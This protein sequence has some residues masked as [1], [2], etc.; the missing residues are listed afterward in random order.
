MKYRS[1]IIISK[2]LTLPY[3][4][5]SSSPIIITL[6]SSLILI[7]SPVLSF[8]FSPTKLFAI[9]SPYSKEIDKQQ[10]PSSVLA[11]SSK[12]DASESIHP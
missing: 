3:E 5:K 7:A 4:L 1:E 2:T 8:G 11:F 10:L 6:P 9:I 12:F